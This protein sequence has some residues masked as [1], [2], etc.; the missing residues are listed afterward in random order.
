MFPIATQY[1]NHRCGLHLDEYQ[2]KDPITGKLG[3]INSKGKFTAC[4]DHKHITRE[5]YEEVIP[6]I[7]DC[8]I[9]S[10]EIPV[11]GN[12]QNIR[13]WIDVKDNCSAIYNIFFNGKS[14]EKYNIA[15]D[16]EFK[17]IDLIN[18]VYDVLSK[19]M[20]VSKKIKFIDDRFGHDFRY[21]VD[22]NKIKKELGWSCQNSFKKNLDDYIKKYLKTNNYE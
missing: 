11:Y 19:Y 5:K 14:G 12:G 17:N 21:G 3:I 10:K 8:M 13:N 18:I 16:N 1:I 7:I 9:N 6:K 4:H 20:K 2:K 15:S 22:A